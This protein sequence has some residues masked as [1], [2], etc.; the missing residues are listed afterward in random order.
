MEP[1][2]PLRH[3]KHVFRVGLLLFA[4]IV[5]L[6]LGRSFFVP[7]TFGQ[8]GA[9]RGANVDEQA[10]HEVRHGGRESCEPCHADEFEEQAEGGHGTVTCEVCHAPG[11]LHAR[12]DEKI[13]DMPIQR[14][15][16]LC[17]LCHQQLKARPQG[18]PQVQPRQHLEENDGEPGPESCFECHEAHSPL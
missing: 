15:A 17:L 9:Y 8:Y 10:A 2:S 14:S 16:D 5:A 18:Q 1:N 11:Y 12:D 4:A 6:I 3:T 7:D 13:A